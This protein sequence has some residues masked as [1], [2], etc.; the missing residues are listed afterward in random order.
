MDAYGV[1]SFLVV[2]KE[3]FKLV[4]KN[5][6]AIASVALLSVLLS[7]LSYVAFHFSFRG[8][9][10]AMVP[11]AKSFVPRPSL[12]DEYDYIREILVITFAV[13][14]AFA[15]ILLI[16]LFFTTI[17]TVLIA[18]VSFTGN[19][20]S[21]KDLFSRVTRTWAKPFLTNIYVSIHSLG[22]VP[23]LVILAVPLLLYRNIVTIVIVIFL[24]IVAFLFYLYLVVMWLLAIVVS[25][26]EEGCY[27]L[28][29]MGRASQLVRG[30]RL[31]GYM[32]TLFFILIHLIITLV[33]IKIS[34]NKV[35]SDSLVTELL[36][37]IISPLVSI[38][39]ALAYTV[40]YFHCKKQLGEETEIDIG[41][42]RYNL[43]PTTDPVS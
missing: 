34:G 31:K 9:A 17:A 36:L 29:A 38:Y 4:P 14:I 6:K 37:E 32:L 41:V 28:V 3:A 7:V 16:I 30:Q 20:A 33:Y 27:G 1:F 22:F 13:E 19:T 8:L 18:A 26:V 10:Q 23:I 35:P 24:V 2:L 25:V 40:L 21:I 12:H 43:L 15:L 42:A 39:Q 11:V 5:G